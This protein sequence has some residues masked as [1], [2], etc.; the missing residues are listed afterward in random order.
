MPVEQSMVAQGDELALVCNTALAW[1]VPIGLGMLACG[2]VPP[3]RAAA[4]VRTGWLALGVSVIGYW[5]VGF[6]F[7]FGGLG[8]AYEHPDLVGLAREWTW[9]PLDAAWGPQD[10]GTQWGLIGLEGYLLR[11]PASTP[12]ALQ[13]FFAQLPWI[14]TAVAV[15]LWSLQGRTGPVTLL[16][17]SVLLA[18]IYSLIGN[19]TWGGGWLANL[20]LN[21]DRGHGYVDL[22]GAGAI[23]LAGA[24]RALAG[25]LAFGV[26]GYAHSGPRQL[27]LPTITEP[28]L[29]GAV[30]SQ[31]AIR[32][33]ARDEPYVPMPV[34]HLPVLATFGAWLA[35]VGWLGWTL[36]SPIYVV[37]E[38]QLPWIEML[39]G[40]MLAAAGGAMVTLVFSW[41]TTGEANALMT[42]RGVLGALIAVG[43]GLPFYPLW[44]TLAVGAGAGLLVPF[45][46]YAVD[47][48]LRLDDPTSAI[49]MHGVPARGG[50]LAVGLFAG[51]R[52]GDGWNRVGAVAYLG[53]DGQGVTGYLALPGYV[54]DWPGQFTA[55]VIGAMAIGVTAFVLSWLLFALVQ[56][57]TRAW[58]GEYTVR[59]PLR[60]YG[61]RQARGPGYAPAGRRWPRIRFV[62]TEQETLAPQPEADTSELDQGAQ[63]ADD[64]LE[65]TPQRMIAVLVLSWHWVRDKVMAVIS[66]AHRPQRG[67]QDEVSLERD[68]GLAEAREVPVEMVNVS[69]ETK[70]V[71]PK[72]GDPSQKADD[73][74]SQPGD[75]PWA[76][77]GASIEGDEG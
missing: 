46:Q 72:A 10:W 47:H 31:T 38:L 8:F 15:P 77:E 57:I 32:W 75:D 18:F 17:S 44:A 58:Q 24:A 34:S 37:T 29:P 12:T 55:Q 40:L 68:K 3:D 56:G 54:G 19:W 69:P 71:S 73:T 6:A 63:V 52:A 36:S 74:S 43:A 50:L 27:P 5:L 62:R 28:N 2:A 1:L 22:A 42:A 11:G 45:V 4:V 48:L 66:S 51:G 23:H 65:S 60:T 39:I 49:A 13:L 76:V 14:T 61:R 59:L 9:A 25:M 53:V 67:E 30:S 41:L 64:A 35:A 70:E 33:T 20:G 7:Q 26:R 21:L 16:L